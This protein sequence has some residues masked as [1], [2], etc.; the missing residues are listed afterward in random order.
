[1]GWRARV[2][3][4]AV[5]DLYL[6]HSVQTGSGA[7]PASYSVGN[8]GV[9]RTTHLHLVPRVRMLELYLHS[10]IRLMKW[11]SKHGDNFA[12][13]LCLRETWAC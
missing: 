8:G 10:P 7:H 13:P 11:C 12:W 6:L 1:M 5:Q 2:R 3:F 4:L 9:N